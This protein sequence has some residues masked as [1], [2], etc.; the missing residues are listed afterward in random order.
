MSNTPLLDLPLIEA[1]QAQKHVT[2]NE[3]LLALDAA[4]NLAVISQ[5]LSAPPALPADGDRY[6]VAAAATGDWLGHSGHIAYREAGAWRFAVPKPGWRL[7]DA[8]AEVFL[9]FDGATWRNLFNIN[10]LQNMNLLG[11]NT[12]ADATNKLAVASPGILFNNIGSD[13]RVKINKNAASDTASLLFQTGFSGRGEFGL[14]GDDNFHIK[15]SPNGSTWTEAIAIDK[16]SGVVTLTNNSVGNGGLADMATATLK[17]RVTAGT[18]DPQDLTTAQATTLIDPF[19]ATLK[20]LA[21]PSGGGTANYLRADGAWAAPAGGGGGVADGDKGD[22]IVSGGG[23]VWDIDPTVI[24]AFGRTLTDD[25]TAT[26]ARTTLGLGTLA[27]QSGTFSGTSSGSNSGDQTITLTGDVTGTGTGSFAATIAIDAVS[28]A[29]LANVPT[30]TFKGRVTAATGDPEDLTA[31]QATTLINTF[32]STLKGLAPLSG[33]GTTNFLRADGT[34]AAPPA[35]GS[36]T[37]LDEGVSLTTTLASLNFV[38]GGVTA[39]NT[40]GAV[41]VTVPT[42]SAA[43]GGSDTQVQYN[44]AGAIA[45]AANALIEGGDLRLPAIA[46]PAAP[47][48]NGIKSFAKAVGGRIM[49]AVLGPTGSGT[50]TILQPHMARKSVAAWQ[51]IGNTNVLAVIGESALTATGTATSANVSTTNRHTYMR[52]LEYLV[53]VAAITAVAGFRSAAAKWSIGGTAAGD[54]G[55]HFIC[56]WG[57]ATGVATT[58]SRAFVGMA[59]STAAPTDVEPSTITNMIGMG[60]DAADANIQLMRNNGATTTKIDLGA[61]FPVPTADR[62]KAYELAMF[63]APGTTQSVAYEVTDLGTGAVATGAITTLLPTTATLLAP[64]GWMSVGGISSVIGIALMGL[65]LESDY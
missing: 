39:T 56:R 16:T 50:E 23:A 17:G 52:R 58:T 44:N 10:T 12:T 37:A 46:T 64:R 14:T 55:F 7:W 29:K 42:P 34:W 13:Q 20:G 59:N 53:T 1:S 30:G 45:G 48:A 19:T 36:I 61:A 38:G 40:G 65:Y 6:L 63:A 43:A 9:L 24:S 33:G 11:V 15:V 32:T 47:A 28:N 25:A 60:W 26:A 8:T 49:A 2:H 5:T 57:P 35:G 51:A 62:T 31:T 4:V 41:T 3:A 18:G 22:I 27:T 21:P 54:G